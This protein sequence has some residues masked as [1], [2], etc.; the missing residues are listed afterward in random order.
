VLG[1]PHGLAALHG[2]TRRGGL[3]FDI[4]DMIKDATILPQACLKALPPMAKAVA[5][6]FLSHHR[7]PSH[8]EKDYI[9]NEEQFDHLWDDIKADWNQSISNHDALLEEKKKSGSLKKHW[10]FPHGLPIVSSEWR[11]RAAGL[12]GNLL[13]LTEIGETNDPLQNP[14]I[15]HLARLCLMMGD[16]LYSSFNDSPKQSGDN[17]ACRLYANTTKTGELC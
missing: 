9:R 13:Q 12:A 14:F 10:R 16:H 3:I 4:A 8:P 6:L 15:M 17:T 11:K 2:K 7:M 1:L 5:W